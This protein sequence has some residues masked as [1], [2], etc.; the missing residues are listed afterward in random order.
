M[1]QLTDVT[2]LTNVTATT[3]TLN[4]N[5]QK[6][7]E[8]F[9]KVL[10]TDGRN[11]VTD[12]IDFNG[13]RI[14]NIGPPAQPTDVAR[15]VDLQGTEYDAEALQLRFDLADETGSTLVSTKRTGGVTRTLYDILVKDKVVSPYDYGAVGDG[16][17][18]DT[19]ALVALTNAVNNS[20]TLGDPSA[21]IYFPQG[22]YRYSAGLHFN[23]PVVLYSNCGATLNYIG[24]SFPVRL[25]PTNLLNSPY[26]FDYQEMVVSGLRFTGGANAVHG[27]YISDSIFEPRI[28]NC[29]F[30]DFGSNAN[31]SVYC[32]WGQANNWNVLIDNCKMFV[33]NRPSASGVN[34]ICINGVSENGV[35]DG[36]NSRFTIRD[37]YMTGYN[38]NALGIFVNANATASRI[39][40]GGFQW[41]SQGIFLREGCSDMTI[42]SV[43]C[44]IY[45]NNSNFI[46]HQSA[47]SGPSYVSPQNVKVQNCYVNLHHSDGITGAR[48][49]KPS[50]G[51]AR[52]VGWSIDNL[53]VANFAANAVIVEQNNLLGQVGNSFSNVQPLFVPRSFDDGRRFN[54]PVIQSNVDPWA[55]RDT[56]NISEVGTSFTLLREH[57]NGIILATG[58]SAVVTVPPSGAAPFIPVGSTVRV[59]N[60]TGGTQTIAA[61]AGVTLVLASSGATGTRTLASNAFALLTCVGPNLWV[62][63]GPGVS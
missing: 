40:G 52:L 44:E 1:V 50:N 51:D 42:D 24:N 29:H 9:E 48:V 31:G 18:D 19:A 11:A 55:C 25:G 4:S 34:F 21:M 27:I 62:V 37:C 56:G 47:G 53:S 39:V 7:E 58:G 49:I 6:I 8:E 15:L 36:G 57:A 10:Y 28:L 60:V 13:N 54:F 12:D 45:T 41:S 33:Q 63:E 46:T 14:L 35:P 26:A 17:T 59:R 38:G 2:N 22:I 16:V 32:I 43:Y 3:A 30:I 61:G 5:S 23:R 20:Y